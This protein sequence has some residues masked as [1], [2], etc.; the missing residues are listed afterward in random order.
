MRPIPA[1]ARTSG[2]WCARRCSGVRR[3]RCW[4]AMRASGWRC[5]RRREPPAS[6]CAAPKTP[7]SAAA[8]RPRIRPAYQ[9]RGRPPT[10]GPIVRPLPRTYRG[11]TIPA[12]PPDRTE[13]WAEDGGVLRAEV[14]TDLVRPDAAPDS[15][16][17][18]ITVVAVHDPRYREPLLLASP[19]TLSPQVLRA[20][21]HDR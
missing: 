7:R 17:P 10:R 8:P 13:T 11:R 19:L 12:T 15:D 4:C 16:E 5:C 18:P 6:W 21:Y 1:P 9:G 14:W 3:M 20:L 2:S